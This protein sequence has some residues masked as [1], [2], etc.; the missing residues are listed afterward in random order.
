MGAYFSA[1]GAEFKKS[2]INAFFVI[3]FTIGRIIFGWAWLNAGIEK[4]SWLTD[5]KFNSGGLI[6][7]LV[8]N[9]V[10]PKVTRFDPLG[11]NHLYGWIAN[12]LFIPLGGVTDFLVVFFEFVLGL[13]FIL[14]FQIFWSALVAVFLN[15]QYIAAGSF[16]NFGYIWTDLILMKF[17]RYA[18][19]IGIDGYLRF[20][21]G[22]E[23]LGAP[24]YF[25]G[26]SG[27]YEQDSVSV[28]S[29]GS[30]AKM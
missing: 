9:L 1:V 3:V 21:K 8:G 17:P 23:L 27:K 10:G 22:K 13:T 16:N 29:K 5:G 12:N 25:S 18:D 7:G 28:K 15:L 20:R 6:G 19:M 11:L 4:F 2:W 24:K 30:A 26:N 14:G